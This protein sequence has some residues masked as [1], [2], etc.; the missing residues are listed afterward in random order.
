MQGFRTDIDT[1]GRVQGFRT[2]ID[3]RLFCSE[4]AAKNAFRVNAFFYRRFAT[5][6]IVVVIGD[7]NFRHRGQT[8]AFLICPYLNPFSFRGP[9]HTKDTC[10]F[11]KAEASPLQLQKLNSTSESNPFSFKTKAK[12]QRKKVFTCLRA[13]NGTH[14]ILIR[15]TKL[16]IAEDVEDIPPIVPIGAV[17]TRENF[18]FAHFLHEIAEACAKI[19]ITYIHADRHDL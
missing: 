6:Q 3:T 5:K 8:T 11:L 14:V 1:L 2:D 7:A 10:H 16:A 9:S 4:T 15:G 18:F 19:W 17:K 13:S 12:L